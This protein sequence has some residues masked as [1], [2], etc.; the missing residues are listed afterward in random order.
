MGFNAVRLGPFFK[1]SGN[2]FAVTDH[3]TV[4]KELAASNV[5]LSPEEQLRSALAN[6]HQLRLAVI[7]DLPS[8]HTSVEHPL[9]KEHPE[10]YLRDPK[11][12]LI[13]PSPQDNPEKKWTDI[14]S[15]NYQNKEVRDFMLDIMKHWVQ[16]GFD[17][18]RVDAAYMVPSDFWHEAIGQ[19]RQF[20]PSFILLAETLGCKD[21]DIINVLKAGFDYYTNSTRWWNLNEKDAWWAIDPLKQM[22]S[23]GS[24]ISFP[25]TRHIRLINDPESFPKYVG[26]VAALELRYALAAL[27]SA[28]VTIPAGYEFGSKERIDLPS[29]Q[30]FEETG[31]DIADFISKVN[32]IKS[33]Y[34][35]FGEEGNIALLPQSNPDILFF[36]KSVEDGSQ[37]VYVIA[38]KNVQHA[39]VFN[40]QDI[41]HICQREKIDFG[42][43]KDISPSK[44]EALGPEKKTISLEPGEVRIFLH[45]S[46]AKPAELII[47]SEEESELYKFIALVAHDMRNLITQIR[48]SAELLEESS[49][50][51]PDPILFQKLLRIQGI[52]SRRSTFLVSVL[53]NLPEITRSGK[54]NM[55]L[56][57][58]SLRNAIE[59]TLDLLSYEAEDKKVKLLPS[60]LEEGLPEIHAD[61]GWVRCIIENLVGNAIKYNKKDGE[62]K[63]SARKN[64]DF[65][66]VSI[67]D[68]GLGIAQEDI[69]RIFEFLYRGKGASQKKGKGVG[70]YI[71]KLVIEAH[72]GKIFVESELGKGSK[73]TFTLP[74]KTDA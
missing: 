53:N 31:I 63:I 44:K 13:N 14:Y 45:G 56:Q 64:G 20:N 46:E 60:E 42:K 25:E 11:G 35:V 52:A 69:P 59:E 9:V 3:K 34:K 71:V 30:N 40:L 27:F 47:F 24:S 41:A 21:E 62:I 8:I 23:S 57:P 37:I 65:I 72:G 36:K 50:A 4:A 70:L 12:T 19:I 33:S 49:E 55:N 66:E 67:S 15:L 2:P 7:M 29:A 5:S 18:I 39:Q 74:I 61:R 58:F 6:A 16:F 54:I 38:N 48:T 32:L 22:A 1:N 10:W 43:L 73:F 68:T 26:S 28:A 17:G 51:P